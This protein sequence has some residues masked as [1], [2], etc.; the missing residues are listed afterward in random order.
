MSSRM[1]LTAQEKGKG[2]LLPSDPVERRD[3]SPSPSVSSSSSS[4]PSSSS[5]SSSESDSESGGEDSSEE[6]SDDEISQEYLDSLLEKARKSIAAKAVN[7]TVASKGSALEDDIIAL[8]DPESEL[9][10]AFLNLHLEPLSHRQRTLPPLDPGALPPP[11]ITF[12]KT[13]NDAP[14]AIRD[15]DVER[16]MKSSSSLTVPIPPVPPPELTKSGKSLNKEKKEVRPKAIPSL[17]FRD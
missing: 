1:T 2:R 5:H 12:G 8:D 11:Y 13:P 4:G 3:T 16:A 6:E 10:Y 15:L 9:K 14:S 7:N 17:L